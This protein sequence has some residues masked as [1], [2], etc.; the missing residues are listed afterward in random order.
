MDLLVSGR[1]FFPALFLP[2]FSDRLDGYRIY[3]D[4]IAVGNLACN[5][6]DNLNRGTNSDQRIRQSEPADNDLAG[7]VREQI[8]R[9]SHQKPGH[10]QNL[11]LHNHRCPD[12]RRRDLACPGKLRP[13]PHRRQ[14]LGKLLFGHIVHR[15]RDTDQNNAQ[16][17]AKIQI[18]QIL[19]N[20]SGGTRTVMPRILMNYR[21]VERSYKQSEAPEK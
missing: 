7:G 13:H 14:L 16:R 12:H 8:R 20:N 1:R 19:A 3:I 9:L 11:P 15:K 2:E 4:R 18:G 6:P 17:C 10:L 21:W 5:R